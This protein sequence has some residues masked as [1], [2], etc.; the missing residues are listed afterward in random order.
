MT[1]FGRHVCHALLLM[2]LTA[3]NSR[4]ERATSSNGAAQAQATGSTATAAVATATTATAASASAVRANELGLIPVLEYHQIAPKEDRW[5]RTPAHF[6]ADLERLYKDGYYLTSLHEIVSNRISTPAG[7]TPY[8]LTFDDATEGQFRY[9]PGTPPKIDP[10][11]AVGI[12]EAFA[13]AHPD[14]G[15]NGTFFVLPESLFGQPPYAKAKLEWLVKNGYEIGNHTISHDGLSQLADAKVD[16]EIGGAVALIHTLIPN[17]AV[18]TLA[19]PYGLV[20]KNLTLVSKYHE[21]AFLV[22]SEPTVSPLSK[23]W[24]PLLIPRI[25]GIDSEFTRHFPFLTKNP[26]WRYVSDGDPL[27]FSVPD[28]LPNGMAGLAPKYVND[29]AVIRYGSKSG[30]KS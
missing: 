5:V 29:P 24:K 7:K 16:K 9:L 4:T 30:D 2:A 10:N 11:C 14:G 18:R 28:Q 13:K 3:C 15:K 26:A 25:Q 12:L 27:H 21:A 20:P 1:R 17:Y 6:R 22:G 23:N 19:Y 8:A